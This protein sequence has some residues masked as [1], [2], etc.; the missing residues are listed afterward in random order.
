MKEKKRTC[1]LLDFAVPPNHRVESKRKWKDWLR[2]WSCHRADCWLVVWVLWHINICRLLNPHK[3]P[4]REISHETGS[5]QGKE[6][7]REDRRRQSAEGSSRDQSAGEVSQEKDTVSRGE[8]RDQ[9][10]GEVSQEDAVS[11]RENREDSRQRWKQAREDKSAALVALWGF[12]LEYTLAL[13]HRM[14]KKY[15]RL[16]HPHCAWSSSK[17]DYLFFFS[18]T[19]PVVFFSYL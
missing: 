19:H 11:R 8:S 3:G 12:S 10:A 16:P 14:H 6:V 7:P 1:K 18:S 15:Y 17:P 5:G 9:S 2:P 13:A 4:A